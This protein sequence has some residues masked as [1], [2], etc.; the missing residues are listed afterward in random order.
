MNVDLIANTAVKSR[1]CNRD[2]F[3]MKE[4]EDYAAFSGRA[5]G[6]Q[7]LFPEL[8]YNNPDLVLIF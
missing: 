2:P 7:D 6:L 8:I 1:W 5:S 3:E 4:G